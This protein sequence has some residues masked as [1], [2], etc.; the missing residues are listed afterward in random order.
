MAAMVDGE[1]SIYIQRLSHLYG[2]SRNPQHRVKLQVH[3]TS[4]ALMA[5]LIDNFGGNFIASQQ[6]KEQRLRLKTCF[7]WYVTGPRAAEI[8]QMVEPLLKIKRLKAQLAIELQAGLMNG[9]I[10]TPAEEL[11]RRDRVYAEF[12][13]AS[14]S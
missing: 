4:T 12:K 2:R 11:A 13:E 6:K 8:L 10:H 1:G 5:W 14:H 9:S 3:N 7:T